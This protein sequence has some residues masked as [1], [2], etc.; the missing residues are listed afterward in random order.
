MM[1]LRQAAAKHFGLT[2]G[3]REQAREIKKNAEFVTTQLKEAG[4]KSFKS[5]FSGFRTSHIIDTNTH[6]DYPVIS[7][8]KIL[9]STRQFNKSN[10]YNGQAMT[11]QFLAP[12][13]SSSASITITT[14]NGKILL[15]RSSDPA[16]G[17]SESLY[18]DK[19]TRSYEWD[20]KDD[21]WNDVIRF[22]NCY[23]TLKIHPA[24][25]PAWLERKM[26]SI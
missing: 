1:T 7:E 3:R 20:K 23:S 8:I 15:P 21:M 24:A 6:P 11:I 26:P 12:T 9:G 19:N 2:E 18:A 17:I 25:H 14:Y 5:L 13:D 22:I 10:E 4:F 16:E